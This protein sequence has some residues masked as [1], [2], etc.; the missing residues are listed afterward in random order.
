MPSSNEP[1]ESFSDLVTRQLRL[2]RCLDHVQ[3]DMEQAIFATKDGDD[4]A[5][6]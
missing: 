4:I 5:T 2:W 1:R 6:M 3:V